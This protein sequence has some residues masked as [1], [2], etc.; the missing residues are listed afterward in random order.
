M[1]KRY[2]P[3]VMAA[4]VFSQINLLG[5]SIDFVIEAGSHH[6]TDALELLY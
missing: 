5:L 4:E 2:Q 6:G 3:P 1:H